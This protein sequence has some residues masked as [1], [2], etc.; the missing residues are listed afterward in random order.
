M[1]RHMKRLKKEIDRFN[2]MKS[3]NK[4]NSDM[5]SFAW[6]MYYKE[7]ILYLLTNNEET[8]MIE[9]KIYATPL[10]GYNLIFAN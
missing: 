5:E 9:Y 6:T 8:L 4:F 1:N 7:P 10:K 3:V 2:R